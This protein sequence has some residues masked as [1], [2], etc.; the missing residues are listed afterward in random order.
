MSIFE[1]TNRQ[2]PELRNMRI[3]QRIARGI[4][5]PVITEFGIEK[6]LSATTTNNC[7]IVM[8]HGVIDDRTP[9]INGRHLGKS[10]FKRHL[11]YYKRNFDVVPLEQIFDIYRNGTRL[12]K[13]C[14]ALTFDDGYINN[15]SIVA[16]LLEEYNL[17]ATFFIQGMSMVDSDAVT[18]PDVIDV[19]YHFKEKSIRLANDVFEVDS[20]RHG[21]YATGSG[22]ALTEVIKNL[23]PEGRSQFFLYLDS[24]FRYKDLLKKIDRN[25]WRLM[26][27]KEVFSLSKNRLFEIGSHSY[28]HLCLA[29]INESH[30]REELGRSKD[31]L[32]EICQQDVISLAYPDGSYDE[33]VKRI[34]LETGYKNLCA[35]DY[36]LHDDIADFSI[37]PRHG[38]SATTTAS[39]NLI[40]MRK[41]F[42]SHG[43]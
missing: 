43:F 1:V 25:L 18:W 41:S 6:L 21:Y 42:H 10:S 24:N 20:K 34:S 4:I 28:S 7:L 12:R 33:G 35:V 29:N 11:E 31:I 9:V 19:L 39:S 36:K 2:L 14:I 26:S 22:L 15:Y 37:L 32:E 27:P 38:L 8:Y 40:F 13:K 3:T 5:F 30:I 17:P 23:D 16:P